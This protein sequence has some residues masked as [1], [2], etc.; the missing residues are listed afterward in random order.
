MPRG[1]AAPPEAQLGQQL[2]SCTGGQ[3][4]DLGNPQHH[5][6]SAGHHSDHSP[7]PRPRAAGILC[8]GR[9]CE[10]PAQSTVL[11]VGSPKHGPLSIVIPSRPVRSAVSSG[12]ASP[13]VGAF[14]WDTESSRS[15]DTVWWPHPM[16]GS[17]SCSPRPTRRCVGRGWDWGCP[18]AHTG[19]HQAPPP[20]PSPRSTSRP[21]QPPPIACSQARSSLYTC[22]Q[23]LLP[24]PC[25][26]PTGPGTP[27]RG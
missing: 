11:G 14:A 7:A 10:A 17:S 19:P 27:V 20:L 3:V 12:V 13:S 22:D 15:T 1:P 8:G 5:P 25:L 23:P 4:A 9:H 2:L 26:S 18:P 24:P 6:L 16:P 21:C